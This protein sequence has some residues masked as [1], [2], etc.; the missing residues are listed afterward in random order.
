MDYRTVGNVIYK[1]PSGIVEVTS[2]ISE[3]H[4]YWAS[5][6]VCIASISKIDYH[7]YHS[8]DMDKW[9]TDSIIKR[10]ESV[11]KSRKEL[12]D[13]LSE[14]DSELTKITYHLSHQSVHAINPI[15][16]VH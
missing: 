16:L 11:E 15:E 1:H 14:L 13:K 8:F 6:G 12:L 3:Y 10:S 5:N 2:T 4:A 7:S 9:I